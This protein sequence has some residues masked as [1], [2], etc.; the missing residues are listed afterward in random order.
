MNTEKDEL[1][2][3]SELARRLG[4]NP[5]F[6]TNNKKRLQDAKCVRGKKYYFA[7]SCL[8]LGKNPNNPHESRQSTLQKPKKESI[9][10]KEP[11]QEE[12]QTDQENENIDPRNLLEQ[13]LKAVKDP[14]MTQNMAELNGLKLKA[15]IL[16]EYFLSE[17]EAIR[18]RKLK[19]NLFTREEVVKILSLALSMVRNAMVNMPNNYSMALDGKT[20]IEIN[21]YVLDD[22]NRILQ[23]LQN[24]EG[25]FD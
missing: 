8:A 10:L 12:P 22:V 6:I 2:S 18:N 11:Q 14:Y 17:N 13:I 9:K 20:R 19:E 5:S 21:D 23:D 25:Q 7:K 1:V 4:I 16:K 3:G 24:I 15:S